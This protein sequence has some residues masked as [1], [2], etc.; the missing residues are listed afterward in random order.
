MKAFSFRLDRVLRLREQAEQ[1]QAARL[2]A[3]A[4]EQAELDGL[5]RDQASYVE[6][7]GDR[8]TPKPGAAASAGWLRALGLTAAAA[9]RQL[10]EAEQSRETA[11]R[12]ADL[13]RDR[14]ANARVERKTL[15]RL[16][17]RQHEAWRQAAD[18]V[19]QAAIDE[20]AARRRPGERGTGGGGGGGGGEA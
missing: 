8:V 19:E 9:S 13:E 7:V 4:R 10:E 17:E 12:Q 16:R 2:A 11:R 14:L 3:A 15:E 1:R 18:R 20:V 5:C 6:T